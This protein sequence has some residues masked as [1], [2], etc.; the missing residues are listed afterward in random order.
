MF[1]GLLQDSCWIVVLF[2]SD[3]KHNGRSKDQQ[4]AR[5]DVMLR[6]LIIS[7]EKIDEGHPI[8]EEEMAKLENLPSW[9]AL[10]RNLVL[11]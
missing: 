7:Q 4:L 1:C 6:V 11:N 5:C 10:P 3:A 8:T 2:T 9:F